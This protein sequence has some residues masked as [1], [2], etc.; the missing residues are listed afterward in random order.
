MVTSSAPSRLATRAQS[1][2]AGAHHGDAL[3]Y[4]LLLAAMHLHQEIESVFHALYRCRVF[5]VRAFAQRQL[6]RRHAA[7]G[8]QYR[9]ELFAQFG[10]RRLAIAI[11]DLCPGSQ[12]DTQPQGVV[13]FDFQDVS[14]QAEL[15]DAIAQHAAGIR[16]ALE[17]GDVMTQQRQVMRRGHPGRSGADDRHAFP[18]RRIEAFGDAMAHMLQVAGCP[19]QMADI[20]RL[21]V[22]RLPMSAD[23]LAGPGA[24]PAKHAGQNIGFPVDLISPAVV[25][26]HDR[27]DIGGNIG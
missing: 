2:A 23:I 3:A 16:L 19:F 17:N 10:Q 15:G 12:F 5:F 24:D 25:L 1:R 21:A 9:I 26:R 20:D 27:V 8:K 6:H 22:P 18:R 14:R 13:Q 4:L 7:G 11:A